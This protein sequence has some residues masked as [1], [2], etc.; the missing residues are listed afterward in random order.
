MR[1]RGDILELR[2]RWAKIMSVCVCLCVCHDRRD[3]SM[4][5]TKARPSKKR[6]KVKIHEILIMTDEVRS[7]TIWTEPRQLVDRLAMN[8]RMGILFS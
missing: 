1:R 3:L 4:F 8:R 2:G 5:T 7:W 6:K